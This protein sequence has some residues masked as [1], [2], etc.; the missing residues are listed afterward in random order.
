MSAL[1]KNGTAKI[2]P[3]HGKSLTAEVKC[4]IGMQ[5]TLSL[6]KGRFNEFDKKFVCNRALI[7]H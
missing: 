1:W 7:N 2:T 4:R 3:N 6:M 5:A